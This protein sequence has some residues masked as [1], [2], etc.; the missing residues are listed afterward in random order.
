MKKLFEKLKDSS[1]LKNH[2][3]FAPLIFLF[4]YPTR[5][6][7]AIEAIASFVGTDISK[8]ERNRLARKIVWNKIVYHFGWYEYFILDIDNLSNKEKKE[9]IADY[10]HIE[11]AHKM[12]PYPE[13]RQILAD[14]METYE[15][16]KEFYGRDVCFV[17]DN[18][19]GR[20]RFAE[21]TEK[22]P[23]FIAKILDGACG[24]GIAIY[25]ISDYAS[26]D[27]LCSVIFKEYRT[28]FIAEEL[29]I[30]SEEMARFNPSSVNTFRIPTYRLDDRI[31][32]RY[33]LMRMGQHGNFVDNAGA[34]GII[35]MIN[36]ETGTVFTAAD[37]KRNSYIKHPDTGE[38][39]V[40]YVVPR[41]DEIKKFATELAK[42]VPEN[43]YTGWDI[44]LTDKGC[45]MVEG[46]SCAQ[47]LHQIALKK[48][49]RDEL[50][51]IMREMGIER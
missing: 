9:F 25:D 16:F 23:R 47:F 8:R 27:E 38:Q 30:Q 45:V 48:G 35:A 42:V 46:N 13:K 36:A 12:N 34:G 7:Y 44:A 4:Y 40:G 49:F 50:N 19:E 5:K 33:P 22:H 20:K 51:A 17:S 24:R 37:E 29:I 3:L 6:K 10:D 11:Y 41:W 32:I 15:A 18:E 28:N 14:K 39:I 26:F 2:K 43:R 21:F 1:K 31:E